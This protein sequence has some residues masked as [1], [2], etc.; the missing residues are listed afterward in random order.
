MTIFSEQAQRGFEKYVSIHLVR[1][2]W[3]SVQPE[4]TLVLVV[5]SDP[6]PV[7]DIILKQSDGS[8]ASAD[9]DRPDVSRLL[10]LKRRM[11]GV[12]P[13]QTVDHPC[14]RLD[15]RRQGGVARPEVRSC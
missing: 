15:F 5:G 13:P 9:T 2:S 4:Q 8:V 3:Q 10:E 12:L 11:A 1:A 14:P 7:E 6:E